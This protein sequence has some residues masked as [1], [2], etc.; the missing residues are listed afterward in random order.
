M[1]SGTRLT[2]N[3][4]HVPT[5]MWSTHNSS[6]MSALLIAPI[7]NDGRVN[8]LVILSQPTFWSY[9]SFPSDLHLSIDTRHSYGHFS[10]LRHRDALISHNCSEAWVDF[11]I[12]PIAWLM[13]RRAD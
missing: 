8:A 10:V 13:S 5:H 2:R 4:I 1:P 7:S 3:P 9:I 12:L 6:S 11:T